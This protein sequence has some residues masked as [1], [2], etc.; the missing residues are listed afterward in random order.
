MT[1]RRHFGNVRKLPS[2]RYQAAYWHEGRRHTAPMTF[3]AK[4]DAQSW[5]AKAEGHIAR[6]SWLAPSAGKVTLGEVAERWLAANPAKRHSSLSRDASIVSTYVVPELGA[7]QIDRV[8]KADLQAAVDGWATTLKPS[9]VVRMAGVLRTIYSYAMSA[10][11]VGRSPA[12]GLR[13]PRVA[14]VD[15][16]VLD[17]EQLGRLADALGPDVAP[18]MWVGV[19][20]GLRW[21]EVAGLTVDCLD[22]LG[23]AVTVRQQLDRRRRLEAPKTEAGRRRLAIP[24]WLVDDLAGLLARRGLTAANGSALVFVNRNGAPLDYAHWRLRTWVPACRAAG[25]PALRFHDLRS[26][27]A[28]ALVA[29]GADVKTAQARLGHATPDVTLAIYA[30]ATAEGDRRAAEALGDLFSPVRARSA[31]GAGTS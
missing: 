25:L 27:S 28:T 18:M 7:R 31:H 9:T 24:G 30:R 14:L 4:A 19:V 29:L 21:A 16:P 26:L 11:L 15:R 5:L 23:G 8:T 13:F 10:E 1:K 22:L 2:G 6:G 12:V 20:G 17:G 3:A